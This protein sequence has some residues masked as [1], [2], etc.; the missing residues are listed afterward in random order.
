MNLLNGMAEDLKKLTALGVAVVALSSTLYIEL[1]WHS[2]DIQPFCFIRLSDVIGVSGQLYLEAAVVA[3]GVGIQSVLFPG[4]NEVHKGLR[5]LQLVVGFGLLVFLGATGVVFYA[6]SLS[7]T[8]VSFALFFTIA[9]AAIVFHVFK[10]LQVWQTAFSTSAAGTAAA[11]PIWFLPISAV[12]VAHLGSSH[13]RSKG[14]CA[15]AL[16]SDLIENTNLGFEG[17]LLFLGKL[18]DQLVFQPE[19]TKT[20]LYLTFDKFRVPRLFPSEGHNKSTNR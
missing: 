3:G 9:F 16:P 2:F 14:D 10:N 20:A 4:K 1:Y 15:Y 17:R 8:F 7:D 12:I 11:F 5:V 6:S 18:G 19:G 13:S